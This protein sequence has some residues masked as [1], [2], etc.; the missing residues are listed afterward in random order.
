M[1]LSEQDKKLL[2][3]DRWFPIPEMAL[4]HP[5]QVRL[6]ED[7]KKYSNQYHVNVIAAGRRSFKTERFLKRNYVL[8]TIHNDKVRNGLGAPTRA[9]AKQIFWEDLKALSPTFLVRDINETE[10]WIEYV[11]RSKLFVF[12]VE[13]FK[14]I[15][16]IRWNR[17]GLTE[18]QDCDPRVFPQTMQPMLNDTNGQA[19]LEGRPLGKNH[20]HDDFMKCKTSK[21]WTSYHWKS[22][23]VLTDEQIR[24][25][26]EDL[27]LVDY[28][29]EYDASFEAGSDHV[30][31][32]FNDPLNLKKHSIN[33]DLPLIVCCD[34]NAGEKPMSWNLGQQIG[35]ETLWTHTLSYQ[36]TNTA[37]MC[38]IV[39][40]VFKGFKKYPPVMK[41]YGD[42]SGV[43]NTS[44]SSYSDWEIIEK[45]FSAKTTVEKRIKPCLS[46]RDRNAATNARL[47]NANNDR[48]M[49]AD[50][51]NCKGLI[52]D[53]NYVQRKDNGIDLDGSNPSLTHCSDAVDYFSDYEFPIKGGSGSYFQ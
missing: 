44:N 39:D 40:D 10:M 16:G 7:L 33:L 20:F 48:R 26:K 5:E 50:P 47:C 37:T 18:Y 14:R 22:S 32:G 15:E 45:F 46:V 36:Y 27:G 49:F 4:K 51:D 17:L 28:Q 35:Q 42:Y 11:N 31:Y 41:F 1:Q 6:K 52:R 8:Q 9:Q 24:R 13:A 23:E 34:F 38:N 12:G 29:R 30:Y 3:T 43:K 21:E 53:W 2:L 19:D 25:A